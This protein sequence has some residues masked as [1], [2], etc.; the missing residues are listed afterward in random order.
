MKRQAVALILC[1]T[2]AVLVSA[3]ATK[4]FVR[5]QVG[6]TETRLGQR[7]DT[8][9]TALK[10]TA[11]RTTANTQAIDAA[12]QRIQGLDSRVGEVTTL[13]TEA[14]KD[15]ATVAQAQRDAEAQFS[16]RFA[17]RNKYSTVDT[18][19]IYFDFNK[20]DLRDEGMNEL[21]DVAKALKADTNSV[22]ELQ[23]FADQRGTDRYNYQLT[24]E[25]VDSVV[26]YLVHRHGIDLRRIYAVGMGKA[27]Q[28][29]GEK[30]NKDTYA[31]SRRVEIRLLAPQS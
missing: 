31:K 1:G 29:A 2:I 23:G 15:A 28:A 22:L 11:D 21:E 25:R 18:K 17:N 9:Q 26:R 16:Q 13:A 4:K 6:T 14:K 12:G 8:Q 10:E 20:A 3:C 30:A 24:R 27:V 19:T 5:E 7:V